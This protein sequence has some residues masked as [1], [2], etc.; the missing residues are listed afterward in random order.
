MK[1]KRIGAVQRQQLGAHPDMKLFADDVLFQR[2]QFAIE[3]F[4]TGAAVVRMTGQ[5]QFHGQTAS[6]VNLFTFRPDYHSVFGRR[7]AGGEQSFPSFYL[8]DAEAA[9]SDGR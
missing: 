9:G 2:L 1:E 7:G 6:L 5:N 3:V 4:F 8:Y